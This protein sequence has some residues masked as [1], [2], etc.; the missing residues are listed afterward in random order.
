MASCSFEYT[1]TTG[2][3]A[4]A[5]EKP[6][7]ARQPGPYLS[8]LLSLFEGSGVAGTSTNAS[9]KVSLRSHFK[10]ALSRITFHFGD[11]EATDTSTGALEMP[12]FQMNAL[13]DSASILTPL[14]PLML[15]RLPQRCSHFELGFSLAIGPSKHRGAAYTSTNVLEIQ[16]PQSNSLEDGRSFAGH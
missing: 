4:R 2:T 16:S 5:S 6:D 1:G 14:K 12:S 9:G 8:R 7:L 15:A 3:S 13:D 10:P 11:S